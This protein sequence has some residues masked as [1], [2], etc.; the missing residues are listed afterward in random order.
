MDRSGRP[1]QAL[2]G[3]KD[4]SDSEI[5]IISATRRKAQELSDG[6]LRVMIDIDPRF[7]ADFH[8]LFP[9]IDTPCAL[10]PLDLNFERLPRAEEPAK[11]GEL[12][13]LAGMWSK[14]K[15]FQEWVSNKYDV[16]YGE[17]EAAQWIRDVC[18]VESRAEIDHD[19]AAREQ[20][21]ISIRQP[22][23]KWLNE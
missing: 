3:G 8:R 9:S 16:T 7:K 4:L 21:L 14:D 23:R 15:Q 2:F 19:P 13:K 6:T 1:D 20:F 5:N 12:A 22:F 17:E 18:G 11:G 10:A